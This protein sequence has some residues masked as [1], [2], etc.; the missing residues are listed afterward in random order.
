[1]AKISDLTILPKASVD[2]LYDYL[3]ILD[4]D[5]NVAKRISPAALMGYDS[6]NLSTVKNIISEFG[7][8][9]TGSSDY[10]VE[11]ATITQLA[12]KLFSARVVI[13]DPASSGGV[14]IPVTFSGS[15][16]NDNLLTFPSS[17]SHHLIA[18]IQQNAYSS[19]ESSNPGV[20]MP[21]AL[22]IYANGNRIMRA[23]AS[24]D[25]N[26]SMIPPWAYYQNDTPANSRLKRLSFT[27]IGLLQPNAV[28]TV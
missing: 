11:S 18:I 7:E 3:P 22:P 10:K 14:G 1:M 25:E 28:I 13:H 12:G 26:V 2:I 27:L 5:G 23:Y 24:F 4:T 8:D 19:D 15:A 16:S 21:I 6:G 17:L 9:M 20:L